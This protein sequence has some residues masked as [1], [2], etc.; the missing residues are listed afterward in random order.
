MGHVYKAMHTLMERVVALKVILPE[1]I[2]D[3]QAIT[4]FKREVRALTQ[5]LHP[6]I[7]MAFDADEADGAVFLVMEYV[8]GVTLDRLVKDQGPLPIARACELMRQ[9]AGALQYAHEKGLVHRDIKPANLLIPRASAADIRT[10]PVLEAVSLPTQMATPLVK[11]VDFGLARLQSKTGGETLMGASGGRLFGTPDYISPEQSVDLHTAD[12]RSDLYSLGCTFY[13]GLTGQVPF[14]G[15]TA[16]E[17]IIKHTMQEP[18]PLEDRLPGIPSTVA[19]IVRRLLA[20]DPEHRF[21]TPA[22]LVAALADWSNPPTPRSIRAGLATRPVLLSQRLRETSS[23]SEWNLDGLTG[24][25]PLSA[26]PESVPSTSFPSVKEDSLGPVVCSALENTEEEADPGP[27][28]TT[29]AITPSRGASSPGPV[30]RRPWRRWVQIVEALAGRRGC[31]GIGS[32]AYQALYHD[33]LETCRADAAA[34]PQSPIYQQIEELIKPWLTLHI[35]SRTE[36]E[37]L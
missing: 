12:I 21:Q 14:P 4:W 36:P 7:V 22:D 18:V 1:M 5:L 30:L 33:L 26:P 29:L 10:V 19:A 8:E 24:T 6:N 35:L 2:A 9:A 32:G 25:V 3:E 34:Q 27:V 31:R 15:G 28:S 23:E 17:K 16:V 20:K 37:I 11:I 13:F